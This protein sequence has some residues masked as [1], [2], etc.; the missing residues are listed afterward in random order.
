[1][2][3][4]TR[5]IC[6]AVLLAA[7]T[8][9]HADIDRSSAEGLVRKSGLW[10]Q[11]GGLS[12]QVEAGLQQAIALTG[13]APAAS[14]KARIGRVVQAAYAADRLRSVSTGVIAS[15]VQAQHLNAL[16]QWFDSPVGKSIT[17][18]EEATTTD[19]SDPRIALSEGAALLKS[20]PA[21][22]RKLLQDLLTATHAA[23]AIV[24]I[25][26]NTAVAV[27]TGI[28]SVGPNTPGPSANQLR[29]DL[30]A[31]R[32]Q[33]LASFGAMALATFARTYAEVSSEQMRQYVT[34]IRTPAGAAFN[35]AAFEALAAALTDAA[36][37][38]GRSLPGT[39]EG[40]NT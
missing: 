26:I 35:D 37:Q 7:A 23:E 33:M 1:M 34:F 4:S 25:T 38:M 14:E 17:R 31:Q 8:F 32:P 2:K 22:R 15:R 10:E 39:R 18:L 19:Q 20:M 9:A 30:E 36:T 3:T 13:K 12:A 40:S 16:R 5:A 11:L 27:Q 6:V 21:E 29:A 28:A 24:Q